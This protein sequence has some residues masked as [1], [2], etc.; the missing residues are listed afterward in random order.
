[1]LVLQIELRGMNMLETF[2][3]VLVGAIYLLVSIFISD[4]QSSKES[5]Q[6]DQLNDGM[7]NIIADGEF[8]SREE[9]EDAQSRGELYD[10]YY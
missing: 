7:G 10:T 8:M 1:M 2:V 5:E 4:E 3:C 6:L 9:A